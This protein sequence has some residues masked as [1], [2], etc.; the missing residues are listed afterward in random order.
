MRSP[1]EQPKPIH[2]R[3]FV[4]NDEGPPD[5]VPV[6]VSLCPNGWRR[7]GTLSDDSRAVTC[8]RCRDHI[9]TLGIDWLH[10]HASPEQSPG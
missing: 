10:D 4:Y 6:A 5:G 1:E 9:E 8:P 2:L 3:I 7:P